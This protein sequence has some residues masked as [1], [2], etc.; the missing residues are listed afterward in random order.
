MGSTEASSTATAP[1]VTNNAA[2]PDRKAYT[3]VPSTTPD[4]DPTTGVGHSPVHL[5]AITRP[6]A[7]PIIACAAMASASSARARSRPEL[8]RHLAR[9]HRRRPGLSGDRGRKGE[10]RHQRHRADTMSRPAAAGARLA[11]PRP[12]GGT[13][14]PRS[15]L[16]STRKAIAPAHCGVESPPRPGDPPSSPKMSTGSR[17]RFTTFSPSVTAAVAGCPTSG[18]AVGGDDQHHGRR[19]QRPDADIGQ[20]RFHHLGRGPS[21]RDWPCEELEH[22]GH[23]PRRRPKTSAWEA[24]RRAPARSPLPRAP[25]S[26]GVVP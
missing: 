3:R 4:R 24:I 9:R 13:P 6:I 14:A 16:T 7:S 19:R 17:A 25:A 20:R 2:S 12:A 8:G 22:D 23:R 15:T 5:V 10:R 26:S 21:F 1:S 18:N 11:E